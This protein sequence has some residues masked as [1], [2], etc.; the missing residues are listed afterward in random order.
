MEN[1]LI[2]TY[3]GGFY[4]SDQKRI[5][6][7]LIKEAGSDG[8]SAEAVCLSLPLTIHVN[9]SLKEWIQS[10]RQ[11]KGK[12]IRQN[13]LHE[14]K[15]KTWF[16]FH[17][18]YEVLVPTNVIFVFVGVCV[19]PIAGIRVLVIVHRNVFALLIQARILVSNISFMSQTLSNED[20][21]SF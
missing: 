15:F 11:G 21:A 10:F 17:F 9:S 6:N 7:T 5:V 8:K 12:Y 1:R 19:A 2:D 4:I 3:H 18:M 16:P 14:L 20:H 13:V